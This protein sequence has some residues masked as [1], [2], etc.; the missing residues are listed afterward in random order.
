MYPCIWLSWF[1]MSFSTPAVN[2]S[3]TA[4]TETVP[5]V[6]PSCYAAALAQF[7]ESG[8]SES[9][10]YRCSRAEATF[11]WLLF[12][13][14]ARPVC[15]HSV[16]TEPAACAATGVPCWPRRQPVNVWGDVLPPGAAVRVMTSS[17]TLIFVGYSPATVVNVGLPAAVSMMTLTGADELPSAVFRVC[18]SQPS[19]PVVA[20]LS[21]IRSATTG[22]VS[23]TT[24]YV[25]GVGVS[26]QPSTNKSNVPNGAAAAGTLTIRIRDPISTAPSAA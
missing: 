11:G 14:S 21:L 20:S 24:R 2:V 9:A 25:V 19:F 3:L 4:N 10:A 8:A 5:T 12:S 1:A 16:T 18:P 7:A 17:P 22:D 15:G 6:P 13:Q 26:V 23:N